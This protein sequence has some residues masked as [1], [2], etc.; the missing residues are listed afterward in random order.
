MRI[1]V[2]TTLAKDLMALRFTDI[3]NV[4]QNAPVN[5]DGCHR[6]GGGYSDIPVYW[7]DGTSTGV[8]IDRNNDA[9]VNT[10]DDYMLYLEVKTRINFT[11]P[12]NSRILRRPAGNDGHGGGGPFTGFDLAGTRTTYDLFLGW[13]LNG[14]SYN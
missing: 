12:L 9:A 10:Q 4:L 13:I 7:G 14:A 11:D 2:D 6:P 5:C 1:T 3:S 8:N